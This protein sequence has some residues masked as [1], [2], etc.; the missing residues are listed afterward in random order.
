MMYKIL[1]SM[2]CLLLSTL[3]MA[4]IKIWI[5]AETGGEY[6]P[7]I[8][9]S[10]LSASDDTFLVSIFSANYSTRSNDDGRVVFEVNVPKS[11]EYT[12]WGRVRVPHSGARPYDI[13]MGSGSASDHGQWKRWDAVN[14]PSSQK[15]HWRW[16]NSGFKKWLSKG[17]HKIH[18]IQRMGGSE[19]HL[20]KILLTDNNSYTP[21]GSG[22]AEPQL[23]I[24]NPYR[25]DTVSLNG[26]LQVKHGQ[27]RNA[28]NDTIQLRGVSLHGL[29]WFPIADK[30]TIPYLTQFFGAE[31]V[32][33]AMYVEDYD[34]SNEDIFWG[35]Y[36]ATPDKLTR[37]VEKGIE[38]AIAAGMYV[39]V[40]WH[41]HDDPTK[42]TSEAKAFFEKIAKKYGHHPNIIYEI[43]N[44]PVASSWHGKIKP[45]AEA[46]I[47][48]IRKHDPDNIIVVGT[49]NWSQDVDVAARDPLGGS[50]IMYAFHYYAA[51]HNLNWAKNKVNTALDAGLAIFVTEWGSSDVGTSHSNFSTAEDWLDF[52]DSKKISWINWSLGN[53]DESSSILKPIAPL[54][55]PWTDS[56]LTEAGQWL[57]PRFNKP[58]GGDGLAAGSGSSASA[59]CSIAAGAIYAF[60][61][62]QSGLFLDID[63]A[64]KVNGGNLKQWGNT[65]HDDHRRFIAIGHGDG[66]FGLKSVNSGLFLDV[67]GA[68][69]NDGANIQ[70]WGASSDNHHRQFTFKAGS[71][72][73]CVVKPRHS[74][75]CFGLNGNNVIQQACNGRSSQEWHIIKQGGSDASVPASVTSSSAPSGSNCLSYNASSLKELSFSSG[76]GGCVKVTGGLHG[77]EIAIADS[78]AHPGCDIR[79]TAKGSHSGSVVID[80]N[81]EIASNLSGTVLNLSVT[82]NC[83]HFKL[84]VR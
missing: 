77:K 8:V 38:D 61:S 84:R 25:S 6:F 29:Q 17:T 14:R 42:H 27:L 13:S 74:N 59:N 54:S 28:H 39:L 10:D 64:S 58:S 23:D 31:V 53:K 41:I 71:N 19:T 65:A 56:D 1:I 21:S 62:V 43:C 69:A 66:Y 60:K 26:S 79:G 75:K 37:R 50:N 51:T 4:D 76:A 15:T 33:L 46:V 30:Q 78:D 55:G 11:A 48:A 82:N 40:D 68:S 44:E 9:G 22:D 12:L 2:Q 3:A 16:H 45:Y 24:E 32:R 35:G 18:L 72:G 73:A 34:P 57:K 49:P 81:W 83:K 7:V 52:L 70:Q 67:H 63:R 20:D 5:E 80:R 47:S 36:H